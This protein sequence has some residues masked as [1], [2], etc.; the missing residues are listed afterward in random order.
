MVVGYHHF[1]KPPIYFHPSSRGPR[2]LSV[3]KD[4][5]CWQQLSSP[6]VLAG[7]VVRF[8]RTVFLASRNGS[9]FLGRGGSL[10]WGCDV[11]VRIH[12]KASQNPQKG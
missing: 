6:N 5:F 8:P 2:V 10:I 12:M 1:R 3:E 7:N 9:Q 11:F 4:V